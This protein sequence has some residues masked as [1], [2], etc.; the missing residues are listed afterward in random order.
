MPEEWAQESQES[1]T[2][3]VKPGDT[4]SKISQKVYGD[5]G[6]Y[7]DIFYANRDKIEDP[8]KL[9]VGWELTI[10]QSSQ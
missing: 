8:N 3:T 10:P 1:Q 4:L 6:R 7:M 5:A 9:E 2:Y